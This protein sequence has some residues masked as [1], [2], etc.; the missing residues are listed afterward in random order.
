MLEFPRL[1]KKACHENWVSYF[2]TTWRRARHIGSVQLSIILTTCITKDNS[3]KSPW[4]IIIKAYIRLTSGSGAGH[5]GW[6]RDLPTES[7][8][9]PGPLPPC[10]SPHRSSQLSQQEREDG[11]FPVWEAYQGQAWKRHFWPLRKDGHVSHRSLYT[12]GG[13]GKCILTGAHKEEENMDMRNTLSLCHVITIL[14][15]SLQMKN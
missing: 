6:A 15:I 4:L 13:S 5:R 12:A 10:G 9:G 3:P 8:R 14:I 11:M 7:L 2:Y 1:Q